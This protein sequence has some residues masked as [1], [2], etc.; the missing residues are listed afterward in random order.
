MYLINSSIIFDP[1]KKLLLAKH[2][3]VTLNVASTR[4]LQEF[5]AHPDEILSKDYLL[6]SAWGNHG[7]VVAETSLRQ[8]LF[9]LRRN[10]SQ[11]GLP[12]EVI[13][14]VHRQG[15]SLNANLNVKHIEAIP[16]F[17]V[18]GIDEPEQV[19]GHTF[20]ENVPAIE[21]FPIINPRPK[22]KGWRCI[23]P[24]LATVVVLLTIVGSYLYNALNFVSY[25]QYAVNK[26]VVYF[27]PE[28]T[29]IKDLPNV[30]IMIRHYEIA[31]EK[32]PEFVGGERYI[33]LNT[34][35]F[36]K[37]NHYFVCNDLIEKDRAQCKILV[38]SWEKTENF[39]I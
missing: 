8:T 34:K 31:H 22:S 25:S 33:Y 28:D 6:K 37:K 3:C 35:D 26:N 11:L 15:Y 21:S 20:M 38:I 24:W 36:N 5:F 18:V 16:D 9:S 2:S 12:V 1:Q 30:D 13:T 32:F 10:F 19:V 14:T 17:L 27:V 39:Q 29:S 4:C 7:L 23:I